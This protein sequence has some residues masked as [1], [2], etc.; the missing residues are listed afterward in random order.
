MSSE[1]FFTRDG[2]GI[3]AL[4]VHPSRQYFVVAE[5][6]Q[7]PHIYIYEYP[8]KRLYRLLRHGTEKTYSSV[9]FSD[10]GNILC[11]VGSYPDYSILL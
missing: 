6:G 10:N 2:G 11:S 1:V 5:K 4:A 9:C 8:S 3:G 7:W